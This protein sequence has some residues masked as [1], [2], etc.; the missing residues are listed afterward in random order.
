L[1]LES[2]R[3]ARDIEGKLVFKLKNIELYFS[4]DTVPSPVISKYITG[5]EN[6]KNKNKNSNNFI[7]HTV[8]LLYLINYGL[9]LPVSNANLLDLLL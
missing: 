1:A 4:R 7:I 8:F 9:L 3:F 2:L 5:N 6:N